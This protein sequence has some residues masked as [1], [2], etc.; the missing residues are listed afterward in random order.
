[1]APMAKKMRMVTVLS[2]APVPTTNS[3]G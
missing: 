3:I 2:V 1:V